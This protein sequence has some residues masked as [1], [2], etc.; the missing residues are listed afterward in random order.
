MALGRGMWLASDVTNTVPTVWKAFEGAVQLGPAVIPPPRPTST[1]ALATDGCLMHDLFHLVVLA[2]VGQTGQNLL[3]PSLV[4]LQQL[5]MRT[6]DHAHARSPP[7]LDARHAVFED[8]TLFPLDLLLALLPQPAVDGLEGQEVDVRCR[9][10]LSWR[11]PRV[12]AQHLLIVREVLEQAV[13]MRGLQVVIGG[14]T[15]RGQGQ[16]H[17]ALAQRL[18]QFGHSGEWLSGREMLALQFRDPPHV[19][20]ARDG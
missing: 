20:G 7:R 12:I 2:P 13:Q 1:L 17:T 10:A 6:P 3:L 4:L 18:Q 14:V 19:F 11:N 16:V 8:Q 15:A 9:L 5:R